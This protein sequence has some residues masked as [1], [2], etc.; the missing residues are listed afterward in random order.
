M[1]ETVIEKVKKVFQL[2][3][4]ICLQTPFFI[5]NSEL[6]RSDSS[7]RLMTCWGGLVHAPHDL[8]VPF[9]RYLAHNPIINIKRYTVDRVFRER[10]VF[11]VHPKELYECA[12]DIVSAAPGILPMILI[13]PSRSKW[14][15]LTNF[16]TIAHII[17]MKDH[18]GK[19]CICNFRC[20]NCAAF[21]F[22]CQS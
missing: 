3:G 14:N 17:R 1:L 19:G 7:V 18:S 2:H 10:R 13:F 5:P 11:G 8:H 12:F 9:A 20:L 16:S 6:I 4:G 22:F 15:S 21:N